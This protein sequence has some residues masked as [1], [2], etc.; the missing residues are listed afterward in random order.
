[1]TTA[2]HLLGPDDGPRLRAVRL[3]ALADAPEAFFR[4]VAE[5]QAMD[6]A[7][8][9]VRLT[10]PEMRWWVADRDGEDAGLVGA[11]RDRDDADAVG[12]VSMWVAPA[13]RGRGVAQ[14]L[15]SE[16]LRYARSAGAARVTLWVADENTTALRLYGRNGFA[17][18]GRTGTFPAP[19]DHVTEHELALAL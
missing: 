11:V 19:R 8:W 12:V 16:V 14:A 9:A 3:R 2:V 17:P 1:M 13:S 18:T 10:M 5:E 15:L 7:D 6:D 4:T